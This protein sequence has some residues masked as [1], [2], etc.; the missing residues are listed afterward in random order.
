MIRLHEAQSVH[1]VAMSK[2]EHLHLIEDVEWRGPELLGR[3]D[4]GKSNE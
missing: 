1:I 3:K 2:D 4:G